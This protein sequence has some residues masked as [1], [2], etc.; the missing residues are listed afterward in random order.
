MRN[1]K[2]RSEM[3]GNQVTDH[4]ATGFHKFPWLRSISPWLHCNFLWLP[5][6]PQREKSFSCSYRLVCCGLYHFSKVTKLFAPVT[7]KNVMEFIKMPLLPKNSASKQVNF[8][9]SC[10]VFPVFSC[11]NGK[12]L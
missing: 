11:T 1:G 8:S 9:Y 3:Q 12:C 5:T 10:K 6:I 4:S 2:S 7:S